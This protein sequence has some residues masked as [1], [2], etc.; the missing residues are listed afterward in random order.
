MKRKSKIGLLLTGL[1]LSMCTFSVFEPVYSQDEIPSGNEVNQDEIKI[2][3][4]TLD[5]ASEFMKNKDFNSALPYLNAYIE[6]KPKKY[7]GYKLRGEAYYALRK[8]NLA[9]ADFQKAVDIKTDND[10]FATGTKVISAVVL[11]ADRQDQYQNPELGELYG[12]LMYAQKA[13]NDNMYEVS[14]KK[15]MEYNSHQY[16]P[17]PKKEEVSKINCPQKY[18]KTFNSKGVDADINAVIEDIEKGKFSEAV[19]TLPKITSEYPNYYLGH[20]LTGVVMSGLEQDEEA[21][22]AFNRAISLNPDDFE[23]YA[24]LGLLYYREAEK[25]FDKNIAKKSVESFQQALKYNPNCNSYYYYI[26][27]NE[28]LESDYIDAISNFKKAINLKNN[29]YNSKY[30]KAIA[31]YLDKDYKGTIEESTNLLF[32]RVS[33]YNSV[34]YLRALSYYKL[35]NYDAAIADIEKI[36]HNMDD[37]YNLDIKKFTQ[38]EMILETYLYYL[39]SRISRDNGL[40]A[41]SDL[42]KAYKNPIIALLDTRSKDF[43]HANYKL[44]SFD[45]DNQYDLLRTTFDD[46]GIDFVY[47]NPDYKVARKVLPNQEVAQLSDDKTNIDNS[48]KSKISDVE[49]IELATDEITA[50]SQ[51]IEEKTVLVEPEKERI[52]TEISEPKQVETKDVAQKERDVVEN[53]AKEPQKPVVVDLPTEGSIEKT[54]ETPAK[55]VTKVENIGKSDNVENSEKSTD[56]PTIVVY[57]ADTLIFNPVEENKSTPQYDPY[58]S[59]IRELMMADSNLKLPSNGEEQESSINISQ[60]KTETEQTV[61]EKLASI[62]ESVSESEKP[63]ITEITETNR[64]QEVSEPVVSAEPE[65]KPEEDKIVV[66]ENSSSQTE[67]KHESGNEDNKIDN[68]VTQPTE[69]NEIIK[70]EAETPQLEQLTNDKAEN[71]TAVKKNYVEDV[72]KTTKSLKVPVNEKYANVNLDEFDVKSLKSPDIHA[73]EEVIFLDTEKDSFIE[74]TERQVNENMAKLAQMQDLGKTSPKEATKEN[75]K[76]EDKSTDS[77]AVNITPDTHNIESIT[78]KIT[79]PDAN[80]INVADID[81]PKAENTESEKVATQASVEKNGETSVA[82][83]PII[84]GAEVSEIGVQT[85]ESDQ[86]VEKDEVISEAKNDEI[87]IDENKTSEI[88]EEQ[89]VQE[90]T[91]K[92]KKSKKKK[93]EDNLIIAVG[94]NQKDYIEQPQKKQNIKKIKQNKNI[95]TSND[96]DVQSNENQEETKYNDSTKQEAKR[97]DEVPNTTTETSLN[98][99]NPVNEDIAT[100]NNSVNSLENSSKNQILSEEFESLTKNE[101]EIKPLKKEKG[102]K[103]DKKQKQKMNKSI[104]QSEVKIDAINESSVSDNEIKEETKDEQINS[105]EN[106]TEK[107]NLEEKPKKISFFKRLFSRKKS[108]P[109]LKEET[110]N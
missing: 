82:E 31:Q 72:S 98:T 58:N 93:S 32:R 3:K 62:K 5:K 73:G 14:Y 23:S 18:G 57:D 77:V 99:K 87:K 27:L 95:D 13:M 102:T 66:S 11:G 75:L 86:V 45:I 63:V 69:N 70:G 36:H 80:L 39:Q 42:L 60:V 89:S 105:N 38:K 43:E 2:K 35:K 83:L 22:S 79:T 37:I 8:Y 49:D 30:Y 1:V 7:Q 90:P 50:P 97:N 21:I 96:E 28:M 24:S 33:N 103:I 41:K 71:E 40:G 88:V 53:I 55:D 4:D 104:D 110:G 29:D 61:E 19:Y 76:N 34:L 59:R 47:L 46:L 85:E 44:T 51:V 65:I 68:V 10:K 81:I 108:V 94:E 52:V 26:G 12:E 67:L 100:S 78:Q 74:R 17:A 109:V 15:A 25:T 48:E 9:V 20:Y 92:I 106:K 107:S 84:R 54:V 64:L 6:A 101:Q 56:K 91:S 16:L